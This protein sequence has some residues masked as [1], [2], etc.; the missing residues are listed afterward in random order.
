M[1]ITLE[2]T[3]AGSASNNGTTPPI[4][5]SADDLVI[6]V[7]A[8]G[9]RS[10]GIPDSAADAP[11]Q[12]SGT[13]ATEATFTLLDA[14]NTE[15]GRLSFYYRYWTGTDTAVHLGSGFGGN[16]NHYSLLVL[17]GVSKATGSVVLGSFDVNTN[18]NVTEPSV[19]SGWT[20]FA[21]VGGWSSERG[22]TFNSPTPTGFAIASQSN[23]TEGSVCTSYDLDRTSAVTNISIGGGGGRDIRTN[24]VV[25]NVGTTAND[26]TRSATEAV[27][28]ADDPTLGHGRSLSDTVARFS[29]ILFPEA[30]STKTVNYTRVATSFSFSFDTI[31]DPKIH[32]ERVL[33]E[34]I[35]SG[36]S[37]LPDHDQAYTRTPDDESVVA[38]DSAVV[39]ISFVKTDGV[40]VNDSGA[41]DHDQA[42]TRAPDD[43][44]VTVGDSASLA[45][46]FVADDSLA[47]SDTPVIDEDN[48]YTRTP[49]DESVAVSDDA[50]FALSIVQQDGVTALADNPVIDHDDNQPVTAKDVFT[51]SDS[52][53]LVIGVAPDSSVQVDD[54]PTVD[55]DNVVTR[56]KQED[57]AVADDVLLAVSLGVSEGATVSDSVATDHD[58]EQQDTAS[59]L[60]TVSDS[61]STV[62]TFAV[63]PEDAFV[64]SDSVSSG[65]VLTR[66]TDESLTIS[67]S[68]L[69]AVS[70]GAD[71]T[72]TVSDSVLTDHDGN[73]QKTASESLTIS[74][75]VSTVVSYG[76][77][78]E[79]TF[80]VSDQASKVAL[81]GRADTDSLTISDSVE[82]AIA[83]VETPS[84]AAVVSEDIIADKDG[85]NT[86]Q[87]SEPVLV[88][89]SVNLGLSL[90]TPDTGSVS[91]SVDA[92]KGSPLVREVEDSI[93]AGDGTGI[94]I[95]IDVGDQFE[96]D[97]RGNL[98]HG[99]NPEEEV[100]INDF[101]LK[102]RQPKCNAEAE[103]SNILDITFIKV[104]EVTAGDSA[105]AHVQ[106]DVERQISDE[107]EATDSVTL[108]Q[109]I[110]REI[111][112]TIVGD[113]GIDPNLMKEAQAVA[114]IDVWN[115]A[116]NALGISTLE[117]TTGNNPQQTLLNN[118]FPLFRKQF[119][120]DHL[121][122][123][124][125]KTADLTKLDVNTTDQSVANRWKYVYVLP[126]DCMRVWR[127]NGQ[128]N[129]PV[130]M[131]GNSKI[132]TNRWEIEVVTKGT[133]G[134]DTNTGKYRALCTNE[135]EAR[136]EYVFDVGND[137]DLLGPLTQ[138]AMGLALAAFVATNFGKSASE[139]AQLEAQANNAITA[140]K[141]VDGQ[142]GT[143]QMFG[144]TS[145]L[146]VRSI[147][148]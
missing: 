53:S 49:D 37:V 3:I 98:T 125:K 69:V 81:F 68:V 118:T 110:R 114:T 60:A 87:R 6:I 145:L 29:S 12:T 88:D 14:N 64:V 4:G 91:D 15:P 9:K 7:F 47:V 36:D 107:T 111:T 56:A 19:P 117:T 17:R 27:G 33:S 71:A 26:Y 148:Y 85:A 115:V 28:V 129:K 121:W 93:S 40:T 137:I 41:R 109:P 123:G 83:F 94:G 20:E 65:L 11:S 76:V 95:G 59:E 96:I 30:V 90:V 31:I 84:D 97:D 112:A 113:G 131:G 57:V 128:E 58:D 78:S 142:E 75:S 144:D 102:T 141:G 25:V 132:Y 34:S 13:G 18:G 105:V 140:A 62:A 139:I 80:E 38:S 42:Y 133:T 74:D 73:V 48:A 134:G 136:I 101:P 92:V 77:T 23:G 51:V 86:R 43:E 138:H 52:V 22:G 66:S 100:S 82:T 63:T 35:T 39:S 119:L 44:S 1:A 67:D 2:K 122:N 61:A 108:I 16:G 135:D 8:G 103:D 106:Q 21:Y 46:A 130:H 55:E 146:G 50:T 79:D 32:V 72:A 124:A 54:A 104:S 147:G 99:R 89:D 45:I 10:A 120:S 5:A 24:A 143:P 116:L 70:F 126:T 127:L